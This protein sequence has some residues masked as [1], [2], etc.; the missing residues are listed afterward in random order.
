MNGWIYLK[1]CFMIILYCA[2]AHGIRA[3]E[4]RNGQHWGAP[5]IPAEQTNLKIYLGERIK[6]IEHNYIDVQKRSFMFD[7]MRACVA[8]YSRYLHYIH[9]W[10]KRRIRVYDDFVV[11]AMFELSLS[12][13]FNVIT[14]A[15]QHRTHTYLFCILIQFSLHG[16]SLN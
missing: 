7:R 2:R 3:T 5:H 6:F 4:A 11:T 10:N 16:I 14:S 1:W 9:I 12:F 15:D 13:F 8:L